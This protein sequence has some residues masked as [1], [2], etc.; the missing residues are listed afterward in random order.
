MLFGCKLIKV[1]E[2]QP[3]IESAIKDLDKDKDDYVSVGELVDFI[4]DVLKRY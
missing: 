1:S 4:K 2:I 3:V